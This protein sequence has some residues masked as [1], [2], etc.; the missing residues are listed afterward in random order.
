MRRRA[1][2][3]LGG[4][5]VTDA[6]LLRAPSPGSPAG[7]DQCV[8]GKDR[9]EGGWGGT[10]GFLLRGAESWCE[11]VPQGSEDGHPAG[12]SPAVCPGGGGHVAGAEGFG[13]HP[14]RP[15]G[16]FVLQ[17]R[18]RW[19]SS[20]FPR[21]LAHPRLRPPLADDG[22]PGVC[23]GP[24]WP[25]AVGAAPTGPPL[26]WGSLGTKPEPEAKPLSREGGT[27][28]LRTPAGI[29]GKDSKPR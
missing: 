24:A 12:R 15:R 19:W 27:G 23:A 14:H 18:P 22:P 29:E 8:D 16:N 2:G 11:A 5:H 9:P 7:E 1:W 25:D 20:V 6:P 26:P 3:V 17:P 13:A 21:S 10:R 28:M 4:P